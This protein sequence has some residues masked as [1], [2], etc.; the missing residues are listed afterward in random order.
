[1]PAWQNEPLCIVYADSKGLKK[2]EKEFPDC[3]FV[4]C[5]YTESDRELLTTHEY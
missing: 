1:M 3:E 2:A 5:P 4:P